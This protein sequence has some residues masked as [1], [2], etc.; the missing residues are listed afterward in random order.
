MLSKSVISFVLSFGF[1]FGPPAV[2]SADDCGSDYWEDM[3][4][5][6]DEPAGKWTEALPIGNGRLGAMVFGTVQKERVQ[7][8]DDT[9][10]TGEPRDYSHEGAAEYLDDIRKLLWEGKQRE[11]QRLASEHF[12]SVPLR[13]EKYQPFGDISIEF[14][15]H[16]EY[17]DY[18]RQLDI[19]SAV[20]RVSYRVGGARYSREVFSSY[21]DQV[22]VVRLSCDKPGGLTFSV[23]TTSPHPGTEVKAPNSSSLLMQG[24]LKPYKGRGQT[25]PSVLKFASILKLRTEGGEVS[26]DSKGLHVVEADEAVLILAAATSFKNFQD[27]SGDPVAICKDTMK[28]VR[29]IGYDGL[30]KA[31]TEDHRDLF[32][33]VKLELGQTD[34]MLMSTD[35]RIKNFANGNDPQFTALYFQYGRYLM[36]ASSRPGSQPANLQGIWN[37]SLNPP[38]ESKWTTNINAEMNYWPA[39]VT[40]LPECHEPQFKMIEEIAESGARTAKAHYDA[41]GWVLH[42]NTDLWRGTAPI[43]ASNHGIWPT[44]GAWLC[45]DLW[46]H[47]AFTGDKEFLAERAYPLMKGSAVFFLDYL[48]EDPETGWLISTPSNSPENGGLVAGPT[49]DHQIIR[50]LFTNCIKASEIL[51]ID[52][53]FRKKLRE[54]KKRIAPNQIGQY[55][56]LQEWLEDKDN[57]RNRH[58][59]VSHLFGLHPGKEI[60]RRETPELWKAAMKSLEMRGDGGT[61][62]S[63]AWKVNFWARFEDGDHAYK[64]L[65][66]LI[67]PG[68]MYPNMFDAHPPFQIDGNFGGVAG[69]CEMLLQSHLGEIHLLPA[70]PSIW[71]AGSIDGIRARG[72]FDLDITWAGG[73]LAQAKITSRLGNDCRVRSAA[74]VA[75][76]CNGKPVKAAAVEEDVI[77]FATEAGNT[78]L[79]STPV[80]ADLTLWYDEPASKWTESLPIGNGRLGATV[81]GRTGDERIQLNEDSLWAGPPVPQDRVGAYKYIEQARKLYFE[82][83]FAEG[84]SLIQKH[85]MSPRISPR[86]HQTLGDLHLKIPGAAE[87]GSVSI[88]DWRRGGED[89]PEDTK[90]IE[91]G[92]DD[93][94]WQK[95]TLRPNRAPKGNPSIPAGKKVVFRSSFELEKKQLEAGLGTLWVGPLDDHCE[96]F[97]NG[98]KAGST[99]SSQWDRAHEFNVSKLL[100]NG[101]NVIAIVAG[102]VGGVGKMA[103]D[104]KLISGGSA[105]GGESY[106]RQLNLDTAIARTTFKRDG[107]SYCREVFS[108]AVDNV[109]V[110]S[111]TADEPGSV[112]LDI[113]MGR[114]ADYKTTN[115]G[116]DVLRM[117]GQATH[118]G[119][120]KG[121]KYEARLQAVNE[122]GSISGGDGEISIRD[123]D[124]VVLLLAAATDYNFDNPYQ[125][126]DDNLAAI[127]ALQI[128]GAMAKTYADLKADHIGAHQELFRRVDLDLGITDAARKPTDERL[129]ALKS[130]SEDPAL[131][132]LYFQFGR[133][134]LISCSR[135]GTMPSNLQGLWNDKIAAPWNADYHVN[136]NIQMNYWPAEVTNLSELHGPF[137]R[138]TEAL[139]PSGR[140]TA[141][142]VYNCRGFVAHHTTDAWWHTSPFGSVG[143]G[144]W[145]MGAAWCTQHFMEHYRFTGDRKFLEDR[146]YPIIKEAALF[147]LDWLVADPETGKLVSGPS[148]SPENRFIGPDGKRVNLSMGPSMDQEIIWDTFTNCLEAAKILGIDDKFTKEVARARENLAMPKIGSDGRLM[149]WAREYEEP[150]PGHRHISHLYGVHPGRQFTYNDNPEMI[151]AARKSIEYRLAHGGGHTGWS[152]AWIINFWARFREGDK[153]HEN[154]VAL[155]IKSTHPNLFDNHPPFQIDGNYGG[156]AGIA[157]MLLQSHAGEIH[158]LPALPGTWADG[159]VEGLCARGGFNVDI[160]WGRG[161]LTRGKVFSRLGNKCKVR[162]DSDVRIVCRGQDVK[163]KSVGEGVVEFDTEVAQ[164][165]IVMPSE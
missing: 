17:T 44:G 38:W 45:Q 152:R 18:R 103:S 70:L 106:R 64:M 66:N 61:G 144:M 109:I 113:G 120:H 24:Q 143:Y 22:L 89:N 52:A 122:G 26:S 148:N 156:C 97:V 121:V 79:L 78:Y 5:W 54:T 101:E 84:Q 108:S 123:A 37:E 127:C 4:L 96:I 67:A 63:M 20:A 157:E 145:P 76:T 53:D 126:L 125:R 154:V 15:D 50:D 10:W 92:F 153:A 128:E 13:Q 133:Y 2:L 68:R 9:L 100:K 71:P 39:E 31:H 147:F 95:L 51:G 161:K 142:D 119:K 16:G 107:V 11:A 3:K 77:E 118:G 140:K 34:A 90:Y 33:R 82:G 49:M 74:P 159:S 58:R 87:A 115:I 94:K 164:S 40:N 117:F 6:Y 137:F 41:R 69:I 102:N 150:E 62:W 57:P 7:F 129:K 98:S 43:N 139:V 146:A 65:A 162:A 28:S 165:Y 85:V 23:N 21:P 136:I 55:G 59:H 104:V 124:R 47:Y 112:S 151:A 36:I 114:P 42:H 1:M 105:A 149:E 12:M 73:K 60:S 93:S 135:P 91:P 141:R 27:V 83:K 29:N 14:G 160:E 32:R 72:G 131:A 116:D 19:D 35:E 111:I 134:L 163:T 48:V 81:F 75:V 88:S 130:G 25:R 30:V 86:S 99:P 158:L 56:Q 46:E 155:L 138:L 80:R 110:V 8:N 132:A